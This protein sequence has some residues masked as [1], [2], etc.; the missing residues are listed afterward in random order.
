MRS[1]FLLLCFVCVGASTVSAPRP[2]Q[3]TITGRVVAY[4]GAL[5]CTNGNGYW[6][7]I[8]RD[9]RPKDSRSEFIRVDFSLPCDK[10]PEWI[11]SRPLIQKF[12]LYRQK[13]CDAVLGEFTGTEPKK[14]SAIPMWKHPPGAELDTLPFGEVLP[15][16]RSIDLPLMPV[17]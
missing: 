16:Y 8:I 7:M 4:S 17:V 5:I 6:S 13:D 10:S 2:R 3:E 11:S 9:Q 12:R 15:C 1:A 14:D